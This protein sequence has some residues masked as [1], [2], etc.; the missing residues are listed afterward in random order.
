MP[1]DHLMQ[2]ALD[3]HHKGH[4]AEAEQFYRQILQQQPNHAA[5]MHH[6]GVI[7]QQKGQLHDAVELMRRSIELDP[8]T[9]PYRK[10]LAQV[11][12]SAMRFG[13]PPGVRR[14]NLGFRVART[15]SSP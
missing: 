5:A 4:L 9:V 15:L 2:Q 10:N 11:L 13:A 7:A 8:A 14:F 1:L 6:L 12:R 3:H